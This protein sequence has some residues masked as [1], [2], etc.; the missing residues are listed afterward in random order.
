M[1]SV[2]PSVCPTL[3]LARKVRESS[4][5][6]NFPMTAEASTLPIY[7]MSLL[8]ISSL[9]RDTQT[10]QLC[11][12]SHYLTLASGFPYVFCAFLFM[13]NFLLLSLTECSSVDYYA[14]ISTRKVFNTWLSTLTS[15]CSARS[16]F[17]TISRSEINRYNYDDMPKCT[18]SQKLPAKATGICHK[19]SNAC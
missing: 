7:V 14:I 9:L 5:L 12:V 3:V 11:L 15:T 10:C 17:I 1:Q 2:R 19:K 6:L 13:P 18:L 8:R 16:V 4:N